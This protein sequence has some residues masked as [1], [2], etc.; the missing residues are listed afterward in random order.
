MAA[1]NLDENSY[2]SEIS[3][4]IQSLLE[5][6]KLEKWQRYFCRMANIFVCCV[7]RGGDPLTE[8]GGD[9]NEVPRILKAVNK[10]QLQ[11]MLLRV[12]ESTLEDQAIETGSYPNLRLAVVTAKTGSKPVLSWL[13]CGVLSDASEVSE[14]SDVLLSGFENTLTER[15][16]ENVV[17]IVRN[18]SE[19]LICHETA[20]LTIEAE[21]R[22]SRDFEK[23]MKA[24]IKRTEALAELV[25]LLENDDAI[26]GAMIRILGT[27]G[28][29]LDISSAALC[30]VPDGAD[31]M[32]I[33]AHWCNK[34]RKWLYEGENRP[35]KPFFLGSEKVF[36]V[37]DSSNLTK[38]EQKELKTLNIR[39]I[40]VLPVA[41]N[42]SINMYACFMEQDRER[43]WEVEEI[44][45]LNDSVKILQSVLTRRSQKNSLEGFCSTLEAML[46]QIESAVYVKDLITETGLFANRSMRSQ[47]EQ[48]LQD[49][50]INDLLRQ[51]RNEEEGISKFF[52]ESRAKRYRL[53]YTRIKW[54]DGNPALLYI[55]YDETE[56]KISQRKK[57][58]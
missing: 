15:E 37:S 49:G 29:F 26:E 53:S 47:F 24:A 2:G 39:S 36:I 52:L 35:Q 46:D 10:D 32:H 48:E 21:K 44:K 4:L 30:Q 34:G 51:Q 14:S 50:S 57:G 23:K 45:F 18:I 20:V 54:I 27:A 7:D 3:H 11:N 56:K 43:S 28:R 22:K 5:G 19:E 12:S 31:H 13:I 9:P 42:R 38:E 6:K 1:V 41:V 8:F 33:A 40:I 17:D 16:F 25:Q 55:L 58:K